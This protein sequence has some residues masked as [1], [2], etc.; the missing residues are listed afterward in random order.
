MNSKQHTAGGILDDHLPQSAV[1]KPCVSWP[2]SSIIV[3]VPAVEFVRDEG[4]WKQLV[5]I[6][7][8]RIYTI[9]HSRNVKSGGPE[10]RMA[11]RIG[12]K[13]W[14]EVFHTHG[15]GVRRTQ[16]KPSRVAVVETDG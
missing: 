10:C 6:F 2:H 16:W 3:T 12:G 1:E 14:G 7:V 9:K 15:I 4:A 13:I 8:S 5:T 11:R